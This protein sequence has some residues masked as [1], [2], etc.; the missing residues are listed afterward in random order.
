MV[1]GTVAAVAWWVAAV[2]WQRLGMAE[3]SS[4][5]GGRASGRM[6]RA[7]EEV[8]VVTIADD[9]DDLAPGR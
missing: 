1:L 5:W 9:V 6:I 3:R 2:A 7:L 8:S 4:Q